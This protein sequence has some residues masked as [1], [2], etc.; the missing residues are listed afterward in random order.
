MLKVTK[1]FLFYSL[2]IISSIS[3][4][5]ILILYWFP[6]QIP[7]SSYLATNIMT[8]SYFLKAYYLMPIGF[9]I[10]TLML[11]SALSF[12]REKIILPVILFVYLLCDLFFLTY[13]FFDTWFN[14]KYFIMVQAVQIIINI[15]IVAF[16]SLYFI[17]LAQRQSGDGSVC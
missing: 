5:N 16:L 11:F 4:I 15:T 3:F 8:T 7:L 14:D 1:M 17:I 12:L 9:V 10:C 6:I 2:L 13:S